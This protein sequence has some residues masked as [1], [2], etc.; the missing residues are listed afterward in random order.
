MPDSL[1]KNLTHTNRIKYRGV[2]YSTLECIYIIL[3]ETRKCEY[4]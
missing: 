2:K 1:Y 4:H 3:K